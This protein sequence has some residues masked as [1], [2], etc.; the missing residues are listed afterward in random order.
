MIMGLLFLLLIA[1]A[2]IFLTTLKIEQAKTP[3][4]LRRIM[5]TFYMR[6][7]RH[8]DLVSLKE[9]LRDHPTKIAEARRKMRIPLLILWISLITILALRWFTRNQ[10]LIITG[11]KLIALVFL[12]PVLE[13]TAW[14]IHRH[15]ISLHQKLEQFF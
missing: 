1:S 12:V 7:V 5:K 2:L 4:E 6:E 14:V 3:E 11:H 8:E 15:N 10:A 9:R 13:V